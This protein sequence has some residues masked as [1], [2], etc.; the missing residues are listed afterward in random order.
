M[1][2]AA[3]NIN[4]DSFGE[5]YGFPK[6]YDDPAFSS[7]MDR[8]FRVS[9]KYGFKYSIFVIGKDLKR[10]SNR[11]AVST[12]SHMGHEIGNHSWSHPLNLGSLP[13]DKLLEE[14]KKSHD[15]ITE[16][17]GKAPKGFIAPNWSSSANLREVL[18]SLD[19]EYDT[20]TWPS[21]L[22]YPVLLKLLY[23]YKKDKRFLKILQ[24][25][26]YH[27][28]LMAQREANVIRKHGRSLVSLPLP[29]NKWRISCWHTTVFEFGWKLHSILL[30]SCLKD[31]EFFYY[32]VHPADLAGRKEADASRNFSLERM[33]HDLKEKEELFERAIEE[34]AGSGRK[35]V[36]MR[37]LS[38]EV[39]KISR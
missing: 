37:E 21:L 1:K 33:E 34:I 28:P 19:Y 15:I 3:I 16:S 27:Y 8:F 9:D 35:L 2:Y 17:A 26:D 38:Q 11:R 36:T 10:S 29:T 22:M 7:I 12:W 23:N 24:R 13:K 25:R 5:A 39:F 14:V 32:L 31:V 20:S 6:D 4:L 30:K 18:M